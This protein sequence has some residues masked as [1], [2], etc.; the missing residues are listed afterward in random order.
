MPT[1]DYLCDTNGRLVAARHRIS[2]EIRTWGE[3]CAVAAL[4]PEDT[5]ADAPVRKIFTAASG[6]VR[7]ER[8]GSGGEPAQ[9]CGLGPCGGGSCAYQ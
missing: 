5:P 8:R 2:E 1:Y 6:I 7:S 3:L 9:G 4:S